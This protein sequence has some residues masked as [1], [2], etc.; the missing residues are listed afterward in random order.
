MTVGLYGRLLSDLPVAPR[1]SLGPSRRS[2]RSPRWRADGQAQEAPDE[3]HV[4]AG[5]SGDPLFNQIHVAAIR[6]P[7][8]PNPSADATQ[9][10]ED[11]MARRFQYKHSPEEGEEEQLWTIHVPVQPTSTEDGSAAELD[12]QREDGDET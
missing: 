1:P 4:A 8:Q 3:G 11:S 9:E 5:A 10:E 7:P 12:D 6:F 2:S